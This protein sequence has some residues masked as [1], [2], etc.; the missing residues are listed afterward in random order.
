[1]V[2]L[3]NDV[4]L[5]SQTLQAAYIPLPDGLN[6]QVGNS[7][8]LEYI[9]A[10]SDANWHPQTEEGISNLHQGQDSTSSPK[11]TQ[12]NIGNGQPQISTHINTFCSNKNAVDFILRYRCT[13][14]FTVEYSLTINTH[15]G[16][17]IPVETTSIRPH[18]KHGSPSHRTPICLV[19]A[20]QHQC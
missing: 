16:L 8:Q 12:H 7:N 10:Y 13:S 1:M 20:S 11:A 9:S 17:K 18:G 3:E 19:I 14:S 15:K 4:A 6:A 2:A 5:L